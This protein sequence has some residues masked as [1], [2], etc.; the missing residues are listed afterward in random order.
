MHDFVLH[1]GVKYS[2][3]YWKKF[4]NIGGIIMSIQVDL[5]RLEGFVADHEI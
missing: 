2:K 1:D 4:L 5:Q 3:I